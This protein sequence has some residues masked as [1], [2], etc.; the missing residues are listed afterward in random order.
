[1]TTLPADP[2]SDGR[3]FVT[4]VEDGP[5]LAGDLFHQIFGGTPP[6][7]PRHYVAFSRKIDG[8]FRVVGYFHVDFEAEYA[9]V[10]GLCVDPAFRGRG[11][12]QALELAPESEADG[13]LAFFAYA[14]NPSRATRIGYQ[15]TDHPNLLVKWLAPSAE[16]EQARFIAEVAARGP[17]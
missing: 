12:G 2:G 9:L 7:H 5:A 8:L 3:V 4:R 13:A 10:G 6:R 15:P 1:M 11:I 16:D 14:G 17:F